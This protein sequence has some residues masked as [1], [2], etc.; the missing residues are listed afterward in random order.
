MDW[1]PNDFR[2]VDTDKYTVVWRAAGSSNVVLHRCLLAV[3]SDVDSGFSWTGQFSNMPSWSVL[4]A[5]VDDVE[6]DIHFIGDTHLSDIRARLQFSMPSHLTVHCVSPG[7]I[8]QEFLRILCLFTGRR[9][10]LVNISM[11]RRLR[12]L[13]DCIHRQLG[14][15][16]GEPLHIVWGDVDMDLDRVLL[17]HGDMQCIS[18][19]VYLSG[20]DITQPIS[21]PFPRRA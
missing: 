11:F 8:E 4:F 1:E 20:D 15:D 9:P 16:P 12:D 10:M 21:D 6:A 19:M 5:Y 14:T 2:P 18:L 7:W 13:R 17:W 3:V